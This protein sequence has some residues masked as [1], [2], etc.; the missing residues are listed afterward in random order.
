MA[1]A[2]PLSGQRPHAPVPPRHLRNHCPPLFHPSVAASRANSVTYY[3]PPA[4]WP[5]T[6]HCLEP[7]APKKGKEEKERKEGT[8]VRIKNNGRGSKAIGK[9][10]APFGKIGFPIDPFNSDPKSQPPTAPTAARVAQWEFPRLRGSQARRQGEGNGRVG[11]ARLAGGRTPNKAAGLPLPGARTAG[12]ASLLPAPP[13]PGDALAPGT[14]ARAGSRGRPP[15]R[16]RT[17]PLRDNGPPPPPRGGEI[18][19]QRSA[20]RLGARRPESA[21][22]GGRG[23]RRGWR[24]TREPAG[25]SPGRPRRCPEPHRGGRGGNADQQPFNPGPTGSAHKEERDP[26]PPPGPGTAR[27]ALPADGQPR[28][29]SPRPSGAGSA[30][31]A[32]LPDSP[33]APCPSS[34]WNLKRLGP[35]GYPA[36]RPSALPSVCPTLHWL[37]GRLAAVLLYLRRCRHSRAPQ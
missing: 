37:T 3:S 26:Q 10:Y 18:Q 7:P 25:R 13:R 19:R 21:G 16:P 34:W 6:G 5:D 32:P 17:A 8:R 4:P 12:G 33:T 27:R 22:G 30:R 15:S 11:W 20:A 29:S 31:G 23:E 36:V 2:R 14:L 35:S 9:S 28:L 24:R 1:E